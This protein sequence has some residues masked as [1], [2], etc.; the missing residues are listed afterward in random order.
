MLIN[1]NTSQKSEIQRFKETFKTFKEAY[2]VGSPVKNNFH[3]FN[4]VKALRKRCKNSMNGTCGI[5]R[6][7]D[8]MPVKAVRHQ[9]LAPKVKLFKIKVMF[10]NQ[11]KKCKFEC[12]LKLFIGFS[13]LF[14]RFKSFHIMNM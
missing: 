13:H 11:T 2:L 3:Y 14:L 10:V 4:F 5:K 7:F 9:T 1:I 6:L 12:Y 8:H